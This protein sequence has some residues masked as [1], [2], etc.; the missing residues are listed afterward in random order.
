MS[1]FEYDFDHTKEYYDLKNVYTNYSKIDNIKFNLFQGDITTGINWIWAEN[2]N[3]LNYFTRFLDSI[4][5]NDILTNI[6]NEKFIV[7]GASFITIDHNIVNN[8]DFHYD[9]ISQCDGDDT[10]I[11]TILFPLYELEKDMG[12][13]EYKKNEETKVYTYDINKLIIWDSCKFLHR[14]QPYVIRE[15]KH[16][17]LVS[18][19]LSTDKKWAVDAVNNCLRYQGNLLWID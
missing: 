6:S 15:P 1:Y 9:V 16:R 17:V 19:N 12:H 11:L 4:N 8:S 13:L 10:H 7:R 14:T 2:E 3:T 18:I 5:I